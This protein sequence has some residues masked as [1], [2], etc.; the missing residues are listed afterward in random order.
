MD[1]NTV[2]TVNPRLGAP[3]ASLSLLTTIVVFMRPPVFTKSL[4][5]YHNGQLQTIRRNGQTAIRLEIN[6]A[7]SL[8]ALAEILILKDLWGQIMFPSF[9]RENQS[10]ISDQLGFTDNT[11]PGCHRSI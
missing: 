5:D 4:K 8:S 10:Y 9:Y 2:S 7:L 3:F 6:N 11:I 1:Y